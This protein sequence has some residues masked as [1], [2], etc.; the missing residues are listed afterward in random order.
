[1][2]VK[3]F[4]ISKDGFVFFFFWTSSNGTEVLHMQCQRHP[5][6]TGEGVV[7][8]KKVTS[9]CNPPYQ[10]IHSVAGI[11]CQR[12]QVASHIACAAAWTNHNTATS[13]CL[14]N[15]CTFVCCFFR[16]LFIVGRPSCFIF[17]VEL[18]F[19]LI[20]NTNY[21]VLFFI[22]LW[23]LRFLHICWT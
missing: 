12:W 1:M 19:L 14:F 9:I 11:S 21:R 6:E 15:L 17:V 2:L 20:C 16:G 10:R 13:L 4:T 7:G 8:N 23:K 3:L 5:L 22:L 18:Q